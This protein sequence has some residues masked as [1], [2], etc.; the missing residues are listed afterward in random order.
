M[1]CIFGVCVFSTHTYTNQCIK[2]RIFL[3]L[4]IECGGGAVLLLFCFFPFS[5][6]LWSKFKCSIL[7]LSYDSKR[8]S[9]IIFAVVVIDVTFFSSFAV[10]FL[11]FR[12]I[13]ISLWARFH[14]VR[15]TN[16]KNVS[17]TGLLQIHKNVYTFHA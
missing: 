16:V 17:S 15:V 12:E 8:F 11:A 9:V 14:F 13:C 2:S 1:M 10:V 6:F 5:I 4:R 7:L 3:R